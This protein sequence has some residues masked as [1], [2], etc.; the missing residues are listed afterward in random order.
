M[1]R[2][3]IVYSIL[4]VL[5]ILSAF[6]GCSAPDK[7][8]TAEKSGDC[9]LTVETV[10]GVVVNDSQAVLTSEQFSALTGAADVSALCVYTAAEKAEVVV[11]LDA[12]ELTFTVKIG[13]AHV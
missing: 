12:E 8:S 4:I 3:R 11:S 5:L 10:C 9:S 1:K 7:G 13:R 2:I 6:I